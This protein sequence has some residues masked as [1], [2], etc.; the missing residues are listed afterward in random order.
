VKFKEILE[1][2]LTY[3][4]SHYSL[5]LPE[6]VALAVGLLTLVVSILSYRLQKRFTQ[7]TIEL[8]KKR[9]HAA[10]QQRERLEVQAKRQVPRNL[11]LGDEILMIPTMKEAGIHES[12][13][14]LGVFTPTVEKGAWVNRGDILLT[15]R[16]EVFENG[17]RPRW[18]VF[19]DERF[20][21]EISLES[22][23]SGLVISYRKEM[24]GSVDQFVG[25]IVYGEIEVFPVFLLP[26]KEESPE[27]SH[28]YF[29]D[30]L[31]S[32]IRQFWPRIA[33]CKAY[34]NYVRFT[35]QFPQLKPKFEK[36]LILDDL[37]VRQIGPEDKD[38]MYEIHRLRANPKFQDLHSKLEHL[39]P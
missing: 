34:G 30:R 5:T 4:R 29:F 24:V 11:S 39:V 19:G 36:E 33:Y 25:D 7:Q 37:Q 38:I 3:L 18:R 8:E 22:P 17:E 23:V 15:V 20:P 1:Q 27:R 2:A 31:N 28:K 10:E 9:D 26:K 35:E 32:T 16:Y 21:I 14:Y 12:L 6:L 13:G